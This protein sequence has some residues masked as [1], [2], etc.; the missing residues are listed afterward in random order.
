M[1]RNPIISYKI[2]IISIL[3]TILSPAFAGVGLYGKQ[4]VSTHSTQTS[5]TKQNLLS[6][7]NNSIGLFDN[8]PQPTLMAAP[9]GGGNGSH[10]PVA[11]GVGM[12]L[13]MASGYVIVRKFS[14]TR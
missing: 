7:L 8:S 13:L 1:K 14:A 9:G 11:D 2:L 12:I 6:S 4:Q 5:D 10:V 3:S